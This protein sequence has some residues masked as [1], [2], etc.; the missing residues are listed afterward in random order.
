[1]E[2]FWSLFHTYR[3]AGDSPTVT[4]SGIA[5]RE[6]RQDGGHNITCCFQ[7]ERS[8]HCYKLEVARTMTGSCDPN[9]LLGENVWNVDRLR[10]IT[11]IE[12]VVNRR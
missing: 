10:P 3:E 8:F 4:G 12:F 2:F 11:M 1:M 9:A 5:P 7:R 6:N